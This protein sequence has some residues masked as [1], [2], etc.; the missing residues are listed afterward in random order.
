MSWLKAQSRRSGSFYSWK[1]GLKKLVIVP[2]LGQ[3]IS[4]SREGLYCCW[5]LLLFIAIICIDF[6][7]KK[8]LEYT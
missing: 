6:T 3:G 7:V 8:E 4:P 5:L 1:E 2:V